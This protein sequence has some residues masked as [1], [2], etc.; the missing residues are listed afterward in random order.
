MKRLVPTIA[1][2]TLAALGAA[3]PAATAPRP[4]IIFILTDDL[5]YGD[6]G[7]YG[8]QF[9]PTP[10][11]DRIAKEGIRFMTRRGPRRLIGDGR[12]SAIE[13]RGVASVFDARGRFAPTYDDADL[14]TIDA[15]A[16]VLAIGQQADLSFLTAADG[17]TLTPGGTVRID[18]VT[19]AT[20]A[21]G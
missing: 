19:L 3:A 4:N 20:S 14:V 5:G 10:N 13:L 9:V 21:P 11:L 6:L 16:C 7:C 2:L 8:G 18:P 1:L 15:D 12:L 17:V